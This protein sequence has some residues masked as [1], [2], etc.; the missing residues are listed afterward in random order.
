M[1]DKPPVTGSTAPPQ[2]GATEVRVRP[3][4]QRGLFLTRPVHAQEV[5]FVY[6]GP[7]I[8]HPTRYSIQIAEHLHIDGTPESN[9]CLNHSCA[10]NA[11]VDWHGVF[12]R[13]LREIRTDEELTCNYLTTDWELHEPFRC[14]CGAPNC[15]GEIRGFK[16][17]SGEQQRA[18]AVFVPAF[19]RERTGRETSPS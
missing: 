5:L 6:N 17:L 15:Y 19:M 12:L 18:L 2:A 7:L 8:D 13:A 3:D 4:G 1:R 14:S 10:P 11:Y 9:T 16:H